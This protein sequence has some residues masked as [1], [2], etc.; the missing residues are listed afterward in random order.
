MLSRLRHS[1]GMGAE[2]PILCPGG[3]AIARSPRFA[4]QT[5]IRD[6]REAEPFE[7]AP[8]R[9]GEARRVA[10]LIGEA[11]RGNLG[12]GCIEHR[13]GSGVGGAPS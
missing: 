6:D 9:R 2:G 3:G 12:G 13:S 5:V 7:R 1:D 11:E 10:D 4:G 8:Q